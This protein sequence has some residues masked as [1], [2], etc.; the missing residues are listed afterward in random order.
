MEEKE[1]RKNLNLIKRQKYLE[2]YNI[3]RRKKEYDNYI[4]SKMHEQAT[5]ELSVR[6][7][8]RDNLYRK[9][10][11][12]IYSYD[13]ASNSLVL[14][15]NIVTGYDVPKKISMNFKIDPNKIKSKYIFNT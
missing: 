2:D 1:N 4:I 8:N 7:Y 13:N 15:K 14:N 11:S 9:G 5:A 3:K 6:K 12:S 10:C